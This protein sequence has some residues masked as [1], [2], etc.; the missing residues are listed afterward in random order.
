MVIACMFMD[1]RHLV[2]YLATDRVFMFMDMKSVQANYRALR[3]F[4]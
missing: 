1:I 4:D 3:V 2:W